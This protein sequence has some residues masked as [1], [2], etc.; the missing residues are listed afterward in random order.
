M[1]QN[2][3]QKELAWSKPEPFKLATEQ[4]LDGDR[5]GQEQKRRESDRKQ[6]EKLQTQF[7]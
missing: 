3:P 1:K 6:S 4:T 2:A 7:V 5:I